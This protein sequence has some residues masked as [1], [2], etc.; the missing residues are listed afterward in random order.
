MSQDP[1]RKSLTI[2]DPVDAADLQR[3]GDLQAKR[4]EVA[5]MLLSLEQDKVKLLVQARQI[6]DMKSQLFTRIVTDRG[7]PAGFAVEIDA[8]TGMLV[9]MEPQGPNGAAE[10][11]QPPA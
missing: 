8:K 4:Y 9:P 2:N 3:L 10:A 5:D 7:L 11:P 6:D 1:E